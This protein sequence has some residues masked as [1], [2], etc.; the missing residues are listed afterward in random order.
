MVQLSWYN[1]HLHRNH[2]ST[3]LIIILIN[4]QIKTYQKIQIFFF[5][6]APV[7]QQVLFLSGSANVCVRVP[8]RV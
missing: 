1:T 2:M 5:P 8:V 4:W 6:D 3:Y 7:D